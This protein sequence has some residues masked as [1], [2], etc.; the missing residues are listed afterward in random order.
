MRAKELIE[1]LDSRCLPSG[2]DD[3]EVR[4]ISCNSNEVYDNFIFVAIEGTHIDGRKFIDEA[5]ERGAKVVIVTSQASQV[6]SQKKSSV[7]QVE[8]TRKVLAKLAAK[9]YGNPSSRIKVVGVTGTNGKTTITYLIESVVKADGCDA[10]VIGTINYRIKN[11]TMTALN[12]TPGPLVLQGMLQEMVKIK[13]G[14]ARM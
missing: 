7:I 2:F 13:I 10:G 6:T 9:F 8:D 3:F 11:K 12:T 4:G 14:Y 5:I 1:S